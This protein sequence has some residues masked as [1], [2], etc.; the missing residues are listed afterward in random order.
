MMQSLRTWNLQ[1]C[2]LEVGSVGSA[3]KFDLFQSMRLLLLV[4]AKGY[5][6][7]HT[8]HED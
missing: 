5:I 4:G 1:E 7:T 3:L 8:M 2:Q 6:P